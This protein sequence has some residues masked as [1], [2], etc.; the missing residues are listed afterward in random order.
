M[1]RPQAIVV[2]AAGDSTGSPYSTGT[3]ERAWKES[4]SAIWPERPAQVYRWLKGSAVLDDLDE[5]QDGAIGSE[6]EFTDTNALVGQHSFSG[7]GEEIIGQTPDVGGGALAGTEGAFLATAGELLAD[8]AYA[9]GGVPAAAFP[10]ITRDDSAI[11]FT[12]QWRVSSAEGA[13][14]QRRIIVNADSN[15][16]AN[17]V[18]LNITGATTLTCKLQKVIGGTTTDIATFTAGTIP[19]ATAASWY[20]FEVVIEMSGA[21]ATISATLNGDT[22]TGSLT[23]G[24]LAALGSYI[25]IA[26]NSTASGLRSIEARGTFTT[27]EVIG[28]PSDL[29]YFTLYNGCVAGSTADWQIGNAPAMYPEPID[30]LHIHHGHNYEEDVTAAEVVAEFELL[31]S[32]IQ[33]QQSGHPFA[34]VVHSQNPRFSPADKIDYHAGVQEEIRTWTIRKGHSYVPIREN[35]IARED[36]GRS[37]ISASDGIHPVVPPTFQIGIVKEWIAS[38]TMRP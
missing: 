36:H 27:P 5:W 16:A 13:S 11:A 37:P 26:E 33:A 23:S 10:V 18:R 20:D 34:V 38:R 1:R 19:D 15:A 29:G 28:G 12:G 2:G 14:K 21:D 25:G 3:V 4:L 30:L 35:Y 6:P 31:I 22:V 8:P 9:G 7:S 32:T 24:G 17:C